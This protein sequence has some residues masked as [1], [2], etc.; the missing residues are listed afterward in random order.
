[1]MASTSVVAMYDR[2]DVGRMSSF[3]LIHWVALIRRH[4]SSGKV[5][6]LI[7]GLML[8][9]VLGYVMQRGRFCVTGMLRDI[10]TLKTW[11]GFVALLVV[12]AVHAVGL[13]ALTSL[14]VITPEVDDFAPVAVR[15]MVSLRRRPGR[16][17][18]CPAHV[19]LIGRRDES[20]GVKRD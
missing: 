8:G 19:W 3:A 6:M 15:N 10:F 4:P 18:D 17:L 14:G 9:T 13:A 11:R 5:A 20:G 2:R 1:M 16:V 7:T 12:I